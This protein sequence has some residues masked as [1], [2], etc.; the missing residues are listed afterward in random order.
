MN[1]LI[2]IFFYLL[3]IRKLINNKL[4]TILKKNT[5]CGLLKNI[6]DII[7][8]TRESIPN[9]DQNITVTDI[10]YFKF[11]PVSSVDVEKSFSTY[12][13]VL[14]DN[15]QRFTFE[16]LKKTLIVQCNSHF[17]GKSIEKINFKIK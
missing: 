4:N 15:R 9:M 12:K 6:K 17:N 8:G 3:V 16:N 7:F 14:A 5:A 10:P 2:L 1:I 11:A 13:T